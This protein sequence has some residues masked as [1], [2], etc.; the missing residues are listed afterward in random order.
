MC[1]GAVAG[2]SDEDLEARRRESV[3]CLAGA[4]DL[5]EK[6]ILP[7]L[8]TD[9]PKTC[10]Q[11]HLSGVDLGLF[12]RPTMCETRAC[13][14]ERGLADPANIDASLVLSWILRATPES[15]L[16]TEQVI[17]EE[18]DGFR[19]FLGALFACDSTSCKGVHCSAAGAGGCARADEPLEPTP[20]AETDCS[21]VAIELAFQSG[22]YAWRDRCYPCH[23]TDQQRADPRAPRWVEV[24]GGCNAA[25]ATTLRNVID[26]GLMN[27]EDPTQSLLLLKP[28]T[29]NAG[30]VPH[31]G[32]QKFHDT[33]DPAYVSFLSF[34]EYYA[35]CNV[36]AAN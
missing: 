17:A 11:C 9:R 1:F 27:L 8:Q 32:G 33:L 5:F 14:L 22:V 23:H 3:Q 20:T 16:I 21:P 6:R 4:G 34:I 36:A 13:L 19:E 15:E 12:V 28:L 26:G 31:L 18:Y 10:N 24:F 30:G 35:S 25:S 2:C 7:L 29:E